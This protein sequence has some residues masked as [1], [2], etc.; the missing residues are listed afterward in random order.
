MERSRRFSYA[1]H[2]LASFHEFVESNLKSTA[3]DDTCI[4]METRMPSSQELNE[5]DT[6]RQK[7]KKSKEKDE[8]NDKMFS[9]K[10]NISERLNNIEERLSLLEL[11]ITRN[12]NQMINHLKAEKN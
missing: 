4:E 10:E 7:E 11:S 3:N 9:V 2:E 1:R 8:K 5:R 12:F 6:L